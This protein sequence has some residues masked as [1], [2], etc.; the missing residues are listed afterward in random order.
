MTNIDII[1]II[2]GIFISSI[3][4]AY[5]LI[6]LLT[7]KPTCRYEITAYV[8]DL[9][10]GKTTLASA[11]A[12]KYHLV[13][14]PSVRAEIQ[15]TIDLMKQNGFAN[16]QLPEDTLV[17]S[18][19]VTFSH[20]DRKNLD[21]YVKAYDC[22]ISRFRIPTDSNYKLIDYYPFGSW[23]MFD[24][25]KNKA[26]SR[27]FQNFSKN[28]TCALSFTRKMRYNLCLMWPDL[29]GADKILRTCCHVIR[30]MQ[31]SLPL[32]NR[33]GDLIGFKW[34]FVDYRGPSKL[35]NAQKGIVPVGIW[36]DYHLCYQSKDEI[37]KY[38]YT[39][40]GD[41]SKIC[42]TRPEILYFLN[43]FTKWTCRK[44]PLY[45]V[46]RRDVKAFVK[47]HPAFSD[48]TADVGDNRTILEK[49]KG[50]YKEKKN[51]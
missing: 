15:P 32:L 47:N 14:E 38:T 31:G 18:D 41:M 30:V 44:S 26:L 3:V 35:E 5:K 10:T 19:T 27:D 43:H 28:L 16:A 4:F 25:I 34:W 1:M 48:N 7:I 8:G 24:E 22:D 11:L 39:F 46:S 45:S 50:I 23:L 2:T 21:E 33:K 42:D 29:G 40:K 13:Y 36:H 12:D 51:E 20:K 17:H 49:R 9:G 37:T 6:I